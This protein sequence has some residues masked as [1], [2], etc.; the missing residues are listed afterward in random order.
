MEGKSMNVR[1]FVAVGAMAGALGFAA[2]GFGAGLAHAD[3]NPTPAQI[4]QM[5]EQQMDQPEQA[6][7]DAEREA[8]LQRAREDY[9]GGNINV[10]SPTAR[11]VPAATHGS[12]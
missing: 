6:V 2:L 11:Q 3:G 9:D 10:E 12:H 1:K 7:K 4:E 8:G 5:H